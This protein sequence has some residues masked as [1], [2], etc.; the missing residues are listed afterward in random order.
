MSL[1]FQELQELEGEIG[2]SD[3]SLIPHEDEFLRCL[4]HKTASG[5]DDVEGD[6]KGEFL[7]PTVQKEAVPSP[8]ESEWVAFGWNNSSQQKLT[9]N[10]SSLAPLNSVEKSH[11]DHGGADEYIEFE[12]PFVPRVLPSA[13]VKLA[14]ATEGITVLNSGTSASVVSVTEHGSQGRRLE[15]TSRALREPRLGDTSMRREQTQK[16]NHRG[17]NVDMVSAVAI[18]LVAV[19]VAL[20]LAQS[21][22]SAIRTVR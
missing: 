21:R 11:S 9:S 1:I 12:R 4:A 10:S 7:W 17:R 6:L 20:G 14:S 16:R 3:L 2:H 18:G 5:S 13:Q 8:F 19:S 15:S 22:S